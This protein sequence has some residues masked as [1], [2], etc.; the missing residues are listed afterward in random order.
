MAPDGRG[1]APAPEDLTARSRIRDAAL[2]Q[3]ARHGTKGATFRGI[4]EAAGVSVGLVQHHFG[5]KDALRQACDAYAL[6]VVRA[7]GARST[8]DEAGD[9]GFLA[10]AMR[11]D[12][13]VRRY[14][15]RALVDGSPAAARLFDDM[16]DLT[17]RY[18]RAPPPGVSEPDTRDL[19]AYCAAM[20]AMTAGVVVLHE[21]LSRVLGTDTLTAEGAPRLRRAVLEVF[22]D[23][24]L[25]REIVARAHA[26]LD[27]YEAAPAA[28]GDDDD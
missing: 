10:A 24:L 11:A 4:A 7:N 15:A 17:E 3:F 20:A 2:L 18:L 14:L 13:P 8:S 5:S 28:E 9:P 12:L 25:S 19:R 1:R 27:E 6:D 22:D 21:H 26:G 16:V 23:R